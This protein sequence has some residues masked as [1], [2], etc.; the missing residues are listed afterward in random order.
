MNSN[1]IP[2]DSVQE[3][4][5]LLAKPKNFEPRPKR[6]VSLISVSLNPIPQ[7]ILHSRTLGITQ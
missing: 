5:L 6:S 7:I 2:K 4:C 3:G 1:E